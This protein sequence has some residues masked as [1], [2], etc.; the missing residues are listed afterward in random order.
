MSATEHLKRFPKA[1][2]STVAYL[3]RR[4]AIHQELRQGLKR[5]LFQ[6]LAAWLRRR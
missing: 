1:R 6:K 5:S 2:V 4:D 3:I